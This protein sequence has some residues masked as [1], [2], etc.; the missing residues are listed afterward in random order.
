MNQPNENDNQGQVSCC[1]PMVEEND[2]IKKIKPL[3]NIGIMIYIVLTFVDLF[4][5]VTGNFL[6]YLFLTLALF[7]LSHNKCFFIFQLYTIFSILLVFGTIIPN[8]GI[9][10]QINFQNGSDDVIRF[11]IFIFIIIFSVFIFYFSFV[12]YKEIKYLFSQRAGGPQLVPSYMAPNVNN[13]NSHNN[14]SNNNNNQNKSGGFKAFS[15][16]GYVVG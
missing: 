6:S 15:G 3:L 14:N 4:Y 11:C 10:I 13:Y 1:Q 12:A 16:K 9:I 5:L 2:V 7:F 8:V